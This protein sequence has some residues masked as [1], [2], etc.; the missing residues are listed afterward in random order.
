VEAAE[1][2]E[3][4]RRVGVQAHPLV[5]ATLDRFP[6]AVIVAVR[7]GETE[8]AVAPDEKTPSPAEDVA[9]IDDSEDED[10]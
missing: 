8:T 6:G 10:F 5:R 9:Y 3:K 4:E 2:R 1:A 7:G